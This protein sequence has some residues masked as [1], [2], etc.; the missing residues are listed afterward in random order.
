MRIRVRIR[1]PNTAG[2]KDLLK[3]SSL[4]RCCCVGNLQQSAWSAAHRSQ[5]SHQEVVLHALARV[6]TLLSTRQ[7]QT[8]DSYES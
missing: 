3:N 7:E 8:A 5:A 6:G 1:I 4:T 2:W